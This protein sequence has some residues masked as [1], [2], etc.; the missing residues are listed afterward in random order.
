MTKEHLKLLEEMLNYRM[1]HS[2]RGPGTDALKAA[3]EAM[4]MQFV[5]GDLIDIDYPPH[6][7][8]TT[9]VTAYEPVRLCKCPKCGGSGLVRAEYADLTDGIEDTAKP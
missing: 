2:R 3:L 1:A 8:M 5:N 4:N 6:Q 9:T 7:Q